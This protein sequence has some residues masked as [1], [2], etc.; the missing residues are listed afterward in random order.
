MS[1]ARVE[2]F[3][4]FGPLAGAAVNITVFSYDGTMHIGINADPAAVENPSLLLECLQKS[5]DEVLA[6]V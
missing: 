4:P 6:I 2:S 5:F 1:G 3:L